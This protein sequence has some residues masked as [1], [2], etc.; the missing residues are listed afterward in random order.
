MFVLTCESIIMIMI[1]CI[2]H[3]Q[4][5]ISML[6]QLKLDDKISTISKSMTS[7]HWR[8]NTYLSRDSHVGSSKNELSNRGIESEA[9]NTVT[10]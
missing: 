1:N 8:L 3:S 5:D 7:S 10:S 6:L 4:K 2:I 9:V